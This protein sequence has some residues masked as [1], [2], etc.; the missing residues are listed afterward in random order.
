MRIHEILDPHNIVLDLH[1]TTKREILTALSK[2]VVETHRNIDHE[3]LVDALVKREETSTTAI[4]DG[5][6]IP[7]GKLDLG[8]QVICGFGRS[9]EGL[10]FASIDGN[11]THLFFLLVSPENYPSLHLRWLAH[12]AVTLRNAEFRKVLVAAGTAEEV[13]EAFD[14]EEDALVRKGILRE[15]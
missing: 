5:I 2:P 4:A 14:R 13:L 9:R 15:S 8:E 7:H 12:I 1:G 10:N 3:R 6:A 11:P